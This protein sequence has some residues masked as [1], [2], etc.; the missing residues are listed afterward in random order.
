LTRRQTGF[1]WLFVIA[2]LE[3]LGAIDLASRRGD[4]DFAFAVVGATMVIGSVLFVVV[5]IRLARH[6]GRPTTAGLSVE[7]RG[8]VIRGSTVPSGGSRS[9]SRPN[10][11]P[12]HH[13]TKH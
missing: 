11:A 1:H 2:A 3:V 8:D 10:D 7:A 5:V 4:R 13:L 12:G 6:S 9:T